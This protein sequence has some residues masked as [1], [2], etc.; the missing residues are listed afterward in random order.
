MIAPPTHEKDGS[1]TRL[2]VS[3]TLAAGRVI[4]VLRASRAADYNSVSEELASAGITSLELTMTTPGAVGHLETLRS[5]AVGAEI[6]VGTILTV[7]D[8]RAAIDAGA[9]FL[10]TPVVTPAVIDVAV[11]T[12]TRIYPGGLTP[13][14]LQLAW[15]LGATAVKLF[16]A[17]TVGPG[18]LGQLHGPFPHLRV[19]PSGGVGIDDARAWLDAGAE[20]VSLGGPLIGDAF[21]GGD[22]AKLRHRAERLVELVGSHTSTYE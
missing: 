13:T 17:G 3:A 7:D 9:D 2:R 16:P 8:A 5:V 19:I 6:G 11:S 12:G 15:S 18:Y 10:V 4:A 22:L 14:E 1:P 21:R 20:A